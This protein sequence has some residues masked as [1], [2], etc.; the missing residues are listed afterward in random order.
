MRYVISVVLA[1]TLKVALGQQ[2]VTLSEVA[3]HK[4][5]HAP[6][7]LPKSAQDALVDGTVT[8][9]VSVNEKGA[10]S[11]ATYID[12]PEALRDAA[13]HTVQGWSFRPFRGPRGSLT[14]V[15]GL[16]EV[17][18][19][20]SPAQALERR[21]LRERDTRTA[22]AFFSTSDRCHV[23]IRASIGDANDHS[24][25]DAAELAKQFPPRERFIER[26]GAFV[27]AAEW[28]LRNNDGEHALPYAELAVSEVKKG[29][30]DHSGKNAAYTV[31]GEAKALTGQLQDA[32][33][34]LERRR[35]TSER[36]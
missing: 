26:R 35:T 1:A 19:A 8:L 36:E 4:L 23:A 3:R 13:I 15:T 14:A 34:D 11:S 2:V 25:A 12:G 29:H 17:N 6:A 16:I 20:L 33:K 24:C 31:R 22:S 21:E 5:P 7:V 28:F 27:F 30:D 32:D 9:R 10:V 18:F